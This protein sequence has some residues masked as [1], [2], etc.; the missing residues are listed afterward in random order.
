MAIS[1]LSVKLTEKDRER[2]AS[3]AKQTKRSV[4][5][6]MREAVEKHLSNLEWQL[7]FTREADAALRDYKK[8]GL[9]ISVD[10]MEKWAVEGG[11]LP[12]FEKEPWA[13]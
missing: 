9:Y 6:L 2:L 3:V 13:K 8:S 5:Y 7:E 4:H 11:E 10:A 1:A 12:P